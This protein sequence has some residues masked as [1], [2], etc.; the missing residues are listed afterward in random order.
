MNLYRSGLLLLLPC[1]VVACAP[2]GGPR[3]DSGPGGGAPGDDARGPRSVS[4]SEI[5]GEMLARVETELVITA[6]Q[7]PAWD[8]YCAA[9]GALMND[10]MRASRTVA[11]SD[12]AVHQIARKVDVVRN[13]LAAM[14]DIQ[15]AAKSLYAVL[16]PE[17]RHIADSR[18]AATV[19]AL[20]SG[21]GESRPGA[22]GGGKDRNDRRGPPPGGPGGGF[23][24]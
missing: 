6:A 16:T 2:M 5:H 9:V 3:G 18:L 14:E 19:P 11:R 10:Q 13:R 7:R 8:D 20:Y 23:G 15:R 12:D 4:I 22:Y 17:Q 1:V 24:D 21:L